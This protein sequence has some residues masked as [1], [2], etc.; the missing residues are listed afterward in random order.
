M[1]ISLKRWEKN[2]QCLCEAQ[3]DSK[4]R[5]FSLSMKHVGSMAFEQLNLV[6]LD[7]NAI[8]FF[9]GV[10]NFSSPLL[11]LAEH[12]PDMSIS[13]EDINDSWNLSSLKTNQTMPIPCISSGSSKVF[14]F[15]F[16]R[17]ITSWSEFDKRWSGLTASRI[18]W[19][20]FSLRTNSILSIYLAKISSH[21]SLFPFQRYCSLLFTSSGMF[22]IID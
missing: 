12:G 7:V 4:D 17:A 2:W 3:E 18:P 5:T 13:F 1:E 20:N 15:A 19:D 21:S 11:T 6:Q 22:L 16:I 10:E 8:F 9:F 14:H